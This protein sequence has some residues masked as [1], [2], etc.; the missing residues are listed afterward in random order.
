MAA[1]MQSALASSTLPRRRRKPG[2]ED[3]LV[4]RMLAPWLDRELADGA[5]A[6]LSSAHAA[7]AEQLVGPRVRCAVARSLES[8]LDQAQRPRP[9]A[10]KATISPCREQILEAAPLLAST[11]ARLRSEEPMEA[12]AV[13]SLKLLVGDRRGPCYRP[14]R[15]DALAVAL[16]GSQPERSGGIAT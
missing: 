4:A 11:V 13:A 16:A 8:L 7:R 1:E 14:S 12:R 15:P 2:F 10:P 9:A 5:E 6:S 3:R